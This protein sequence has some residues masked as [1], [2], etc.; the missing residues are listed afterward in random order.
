MSPS[1]LPAHP[2][3]PQIFQILLA[4]CCPRAESAQKAQNSHSTPRVLFLHCFNDLT[5]IF[6]PYEMGRGTIC[7]LWC[8]PTRKPL[9]SCGW[10]NL[11][12]FK[13]KKS[14]CHS[15]YISSAQWAGAA[16]SY[17]LRKQR[18]GTRPSVMI[19]LCLAT[20]ATV[21]L[22]MITCS[23]NMRRMIGTYISFRRREEENS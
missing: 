10:L 13:L 8:C 5:R 3:R 18:F 9:V 15:C 4:Q 17:H 6:S 22:G 14:A 20:G 12:I 21:V 7:C 19:K 2:L 11:I 23:V 16:R 1:L